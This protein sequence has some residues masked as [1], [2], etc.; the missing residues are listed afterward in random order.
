M[1]IDGR[2]EVLAAQFLFWV[3]LPVVLGA[4]LRWALLAWLV[5]GNLDTTGPSLAVSAGIGWM[6]ASKGILL[7]LYLWWRLRHTKSAILPS[8][9]TRLWLLL[10]AYAA[11]A[12]LWSPF[13][14]AAGKLVGNMVGTLISLVVLEKA[15]RR[16]LIQGRMIALLIVISLA[17]GGLQ[18]FYYGGAAYGFDGSSQPTRFSSFVSAQQ[19]AAFLVAFLAAALWYPNVRQLVRWSLV[20]GIVSALALNGSRT[21]VL[22]AFLAVL[23]YL[24]Y[25]SRRI[26]T[27]VSLALGTAVFGLLLALNLSPWNS[28]L[29]DGVSSR[30]TATLRAVVTG[31]DTPHDV[32]LANLNFRL[33]IYSGAAD[34]LRNGDVREIVFGHGTS[35]GGNV[36]LRVFPRSYRADRIDPNRAIHNEWLRALYEWG[37]VGLGL[38]VAAL[39]T[40]I[41]AL[42]LRHRKQ[43]ASI[44]CGAVL[45]FI[46]AF[47]LAFSTE[48]VIAGAGNAVT[49][50]LALMVALSW[51]PELSKLPRRVR[52]N[53]LCALPC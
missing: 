23:V 42:V 47:L 33:S 16:G 43:A 49:L 53:D 14:L 17:L 45:S 37:I 18:T 29:L 10:V 51:A 13:P 28:G 1:P 22:G 30:V 36:L 15:A 19:Y 24:W 12:S 40:L 5:M 6:N 48:N 46:P 4:P 38:L 21:W 34:E 3:L 8:L 20:I 41:G 26:I 31:Q 44:G 2:P 7:P 39:T 35:S 11:I 50:S 27:Y 32:G 25:S 9:P 52:S